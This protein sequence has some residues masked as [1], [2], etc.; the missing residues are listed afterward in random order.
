MIHSGLVFE[1]DVDPAACS[2]FSGSFQGYSFSE[3]AFFVG[4][5]MVPGLNGIHESDVIKVWMHF[6]EI[7]SE[8]LRRL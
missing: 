7:L 4:F 3:L 6:E 2:S 1:A 8:I 5:E